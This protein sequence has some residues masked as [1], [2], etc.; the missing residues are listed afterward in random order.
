MGGLGGSSGPR[1][2]CA[3]RGLDSQENVPLLAE[4]AS[5]DAAQAFAWSAQRDTSSAG[6]VGTSLLHF[7]TES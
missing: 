3:S 4:D 1:Q 6:T 7:R 5:P 2:A